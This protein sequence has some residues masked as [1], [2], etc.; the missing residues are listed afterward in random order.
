MYLVLTR[1]G[2]VLV[3]CGWVS[4]LSP[5]RDANAFI[6][7]CVLQVDRHY[8]LNGPCNIEF[9]G[10]GSFSIGAGERSRSKYFAYVNVDKSTGKASG[11]WN[12]EYG[13]SHAHEDLGELVREGACWANTRARVCAMR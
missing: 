6:G 10:D 13:E 2:M 9:L 5:I 8:Y 12:G 3:S 11:Y 4:I 1:L 7:R